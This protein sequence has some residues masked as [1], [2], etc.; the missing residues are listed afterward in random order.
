MPFM[1]INTTR[2]G[3]WDGPRKGEAER[4][5]SCRWVIVMVTYTRYTRKKS[6]ARTDL[7]IR[8]MFGNVQ[9]PVKK[10]RLFFP[11][12]LS[13]FASW[14]RSRAACWWSGNGFWTLELWNEKRIEN[15]EVLNKASGHQ[16]PALTSSADDSISNIFEAFAVA[17]VL[18]PSPARSSIFIIFWW[19]NKNNGEKDFFRLPW[20][21]WGGCCELCDVE[22]ILRYFHFV[23]TRAQTS[24]FSFFA[25]SAFLCER[26]LD[27]VW[28]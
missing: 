19:Y 9:W 16:Q 20:E 24:S 13:V 17:H 18:T 6:K 4:R 26:M 14:C 12:F 5:E 15:S 7:S 28:K 10:M 3:R 23:K 2:L 21:G 8:L 27:E 25:F 1:C 11:F 22:V